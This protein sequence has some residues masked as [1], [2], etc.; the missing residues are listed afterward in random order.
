MFH[1]H[2]KWVIRSIWCGSRPTFLLENRGFPSPRPS[3][4]YFLGCNCYLIRFSHS[5]CSEPTN[6]S[7]RRRPFTLENH[8]ITSW[9]VSRTHE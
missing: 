3:T 5:S 6:N 9:G 7:D 4:Y 1:Q 2:T 8:T